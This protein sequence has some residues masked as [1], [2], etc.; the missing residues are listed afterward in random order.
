VPAGHRS[1]AWRLTYR[2]AERTLSAKEVE[3]RKQRLVKTL[4]TELGVRQRA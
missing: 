2:H 3:G 1:L 4:E